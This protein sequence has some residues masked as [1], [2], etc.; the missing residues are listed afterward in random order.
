MHAYPLLLVLIGAVCHA[1]WN[2]FAK[3]AVGGR[4]FVWLYGLVSSLL[5]LPLISFWGDA[6]GLGISLLLVAAASGVVHIFYAI[7]LQHGYRSADLSVVYPVARGTGPLFAVLGAIHFLHEQPSWVG[8][9][10]ILAIL[11]GVLYMGGA[12]NPAALFRQPHLL[13]GVY[14][15]GITGGFIALY[16]LLDAWA[17]K[18][19]ER[20]PIAF[21][22]ISLWVRTCLLAP[23]VIRDLPTLKFQWQKHGRYIIAVGLLSP[24]AYL[25]TLYAMTMAPVSYVAPARE[26]SMLFGVLFATHLLAEKEAPA[27]LWGTLCIALGV[28]MLGIA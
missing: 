9:V 20:H 17:V 5:V 10:G 4:H 1:L 19:L 8:W 25:L 27:R 2:Y 28:I 24:L 14:W 7:S 11:S 22:S 18:V 12:R 13:K 26:I 23:F 3:R 21:Y 15:G 6:S 16:T